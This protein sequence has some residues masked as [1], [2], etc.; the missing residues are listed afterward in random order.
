[1]KKTF[2]IVCV[3]IAQKGARIII[4]MSY[5]EMTVLVGFGRLGSAE[6]KG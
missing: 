2:A 1:M 6:D 4:F 5:P 3:F